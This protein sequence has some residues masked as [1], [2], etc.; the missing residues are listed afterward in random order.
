MTIYELRKQ[1][2]DDE[3]GK[4]IQVIKT[5]LFKSRI[6]ELTREARQLGSEDPKHF[7]WVYANQKEA[8]NVV[9]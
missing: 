6:G 8:K 4:K 3:A 9:I 7:Y 5:E 1:P 2:V